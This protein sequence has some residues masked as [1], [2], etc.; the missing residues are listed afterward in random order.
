MLVWKCC[1]G[2]ASWICNLM[3]CSSIIFQLFDYDN[4]IDD[5]AIRPPTLSFLPASTEELR[6]HWEHWCNLPAAVFCKCWLHFLMIDGLFPLLLAARLTGWVLLRQACVWLWL[7]HPLHHHQQVRKIIIIII[8]ST[9]PE[10]SLP[11]CEER[12]RW[13]FTQSLK[14]LSGLQ[15]R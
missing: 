9:C 7:S 5:A 11:A 6:L 1:G 12:L 2:A 15:P 8:T 4:V 10:K 14:S 13:N 3:L